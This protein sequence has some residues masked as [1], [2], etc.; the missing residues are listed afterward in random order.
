[1]FN[2]RASISGY[3][4]LSKTTT[5]HRAHNQ[6]I[7]ELVKRLQI[8]SP[9]L[10]NGLNSLI[11]LRN[12]PME[13]YKAGHTSSYKIEFPIYSTKSNYPSDIEVLTESHLPQQ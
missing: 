9:K 5:D 1:M 3:R 13:N 6:E 2:R 12:L 7:Q 10:E 11:E 8:H 4:K